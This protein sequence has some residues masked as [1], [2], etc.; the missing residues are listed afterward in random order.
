VVLSRALSAG[1]AAVAEGIR[2]TAALT[3]IM[4]G[5]VATEPRVQLDYAVAVAA[6][7][8]VEAAE[9][10]DPSSVRLLI[11]AQVGPVR[12]ID[13]CAATSVRPAVPAT[14]ATNRRVV[15]Q[16]ERIG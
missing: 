8:L 9:L 7:T 13:N 1:Q 14:A 3:G 16:L 15:R 6:D 2:S 11:A 10:G 5:V 12:L 4:R